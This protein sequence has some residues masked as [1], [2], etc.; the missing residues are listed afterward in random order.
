MPKRPS[1][2]SKTEDTRK[3][4]AGQSVLNNP[5]A[6]LYRAAAADQLARLEEDPAIDDQEKLAALFDV[7]DNVTNVI[8]RLT[9]SAPEK[10][11]ELW[12]NRP[13]KTE[14]IFDFI[15]RVYGQYIGRIRKSDLRRLDFSLYKSLYYQKHKDETDVDLPT[16]KEAN[17][18]LLAQLEGTVSL[19]DI[20]NEMP[21]VLRERLRLYR[22][23]SSRK[24]RRDSPKPT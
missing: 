1:K 21:A 23:V 17:D 11:P 8:D 24:R 22:T 13:D 3:I 10:A 2:S 20:R 7:L 19:T 4:G 14:K 16:I 12:K 15:R 18:R 9:R 5:L 6:N